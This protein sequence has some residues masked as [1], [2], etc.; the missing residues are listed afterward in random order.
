MLRWGQIDA[1]QLDLATECYRPD[2]FRQAAADAALDAPR[3]DFKLEGAHADPW[4]VSSIR[5][6]IVMPPDT[7]LGSQAFDARKSQAYALSF[8]VTRALG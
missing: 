5:G 3:D 2:V 8:A 7:I 1:T 4:L 6:Q